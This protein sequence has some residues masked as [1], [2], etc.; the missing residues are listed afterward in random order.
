M[1]LRP[2]QQ[3][4]VT[5]IRNAYKTYRAPLYVLPTGGGKTFTF[6]YIALHAMKKGNIVW[7]MAHRA[8]LIDQIHK[9]LNQMGCDHGIVCAGYMP[10]HLKTVQIC[11]VQSV[12]NRLDKVKSPDLI[13]TDECHHSTS[14]TYIKIYNHFPESKLLGVTATP[15]RLDGKGLGIVYDKMILGVSVRKLMD[16]GFLCK[17][18]YYAPPLKFNLDDV[19]KT[20]GDYN[21]KQLEETVDKRQ[22]IGDAVKHY[23]KLANNT[24]AI[25]FCVSVNHCHHVFEQFEQAGVSCRII[26]GKL[27]KQ[28]RK[29][30]VQDFTNCE[31]KILIACEII[32]EGFD[33]PRVQTAILLRPTASLSMHLQQIGRVLRP[34]EGKDYAII[35]DHAGNCLKHGL[36]EEERKWSLENKRKKKRS[37]NVEVNTK[38]KQCPKCYIVHEFANKCPNCG[39]EYPIN[40]RTLNEVEG[41]LKEIDPQ[42]LK[43]QRKQEQGKA[44]TM[45]D[46]INLARIRKYKNPVA[47]A[48]HIFRARQRKY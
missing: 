23:K 8:E 6:S 21:K 3:S 17:T 42:L 1:N 15:Q 10:D 29:K 32:S 18:K 48:G 12:V 14:S 28:R 26:H 16:M 47:W 24:Q 45:D 46:L 36:A 27:K 37:K 44:K 41:E 11:S 25:A 2:Y 43:R 40:D 31:F 38:I 39:Y 35:I 30:L 13:I 4:G 9:S 5:A 34:F 19:K 7:I 20:A 33:I 22:I